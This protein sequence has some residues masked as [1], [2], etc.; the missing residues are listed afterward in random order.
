LKIVFM[1]TPEFSV[2]CLEQLINDGHDVQTVF[3]QPDKPKGR[4]NTV[5]ASPVKLSAVKNGITVL[6]PQSL[7]N[8]DVWETIS[9]LNP[10]FIVVVAYGRILPV[11]V[12]SIPK[13]G[14][15]NIH[16][17]LLPKYRGAAPI[18]W[19][20]INGETETGIT[21]MLMNEGLDTG[22]IILMEKNSY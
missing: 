19:A 5:T 18:Q 12:L 14:C 2:L 11:E 15:V 9:G 4:G 3:T 8:K 6:Q 13:F 10:D 22:D 1:G 17:S 7:R 16:A 20:I 21:S